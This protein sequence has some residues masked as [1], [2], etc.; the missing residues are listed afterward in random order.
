MV[1]ICIYLLISDVE[2][3]FIYLLDTCMSSLGKCLLRSSAHFL[4]RLFVFLLLSCICY[5]YILDMNL[6]SDVSFE[7]I[8]SHSVGY[9]FVLLIVPFAVQ[10]LFSLMWSLLFIFCFSFSCL[11]RHN[12]KIL[13]RP[14]SKNILCMFSSGSFMVSGLVFEFHPF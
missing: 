7:N 2:H 14:M 4:I 13:L 12:Q 6:L 5:L 9:P 8:F 3:L 11:R 10:K 1:L